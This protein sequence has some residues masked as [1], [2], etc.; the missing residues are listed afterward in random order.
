[1][2]D[3]LTITLNPAVDISTSVPRLAPEHKLRCTGERRDPG[4]GGVNVARVIHRLGGD[5]AAAFTS[6]GATG[7]RLQQMLTSERLPQL[8]L[9]IEQE[10]RE[11]FTVLETETHREYRF[12]LPGPHLSAPELRDILQ[13]LAG[14]MAGARFVVCSGGLTPGAPAKTYAQ[15]ARMAATAGARFVL[16]SSGEA[17]QA[18]VAQGVYLVKPSLSELQQLAGR[19]LSDLSEIE[20]A[21]R[22]V[23]DAGK[24][25]IVAVS[26]GARGAL[27]ATRDG[28]MRAEALAVNVAG[29]V[30]AGDS[31]LGAMIWSL[32]AS[33]D[34]ERA[35]RF[36]VGASAAS[37]QTSGTQLCT[38]ADALRLAEQVKIA[39][40]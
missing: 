34:V 13:R 22:K 30:G 25:E 39:R 18:A 2:A 7:Q 3:I 28:V 15:L 14:A 16:D 9:T 8:P 35:L 4:G 33:E 29:S 40:S 31:F 37:L 17:L 1:M 32:A 20:T 27:V 21:A 23:I 10:T 11:S 26:L 38:R 19:A 5:V 12:V 6:G 36:A 24:A